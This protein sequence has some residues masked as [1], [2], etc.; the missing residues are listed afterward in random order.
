[1]LVT[2][3]IR[4]KLQLHA[5]FASLYRK[6]QCVNASCATKSV[7]LL[8]KLILDTVELLEFLCHAIETFLS[9]D[10][11]AIYNVV[12]MACEEITEKYTHRDRHKEKNR[13]SN[14]PKTNK[15]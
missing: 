12:T 11:A 8:S 10:A 6:L 7:A 14:W 2:Y 13:I 1:M 3:V 5:C 4:N 9:L 15:I